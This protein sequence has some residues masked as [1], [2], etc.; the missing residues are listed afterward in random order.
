MAWAMVAWR[1]ARSSDVRAWW[2]GGVRSGVAAAVGVRA[3]CAAPCGGPRAGVMRPGGPRAGS[4]CEPLCA[5]KPPIALFVG[6][7]GVRC[8][9]PFTIDASTL[10]S[11]HSS[12]NPSTNANLPSLLNL[13]RSNPAP[14]LASCLQNSYSLIQDTS[15]TLRPSSS[16][17]SSELLLSASHRNRV[18]S[19]FALAPRVLVRRSS[20]SS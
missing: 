20:E 12:L 11:K 5:G 2:P 18:I 15:T 1:C 4:A 6:D 10:L 16:P 7:C 9:A 3:G 13:S 8:S 14:F 17:P 19:Q